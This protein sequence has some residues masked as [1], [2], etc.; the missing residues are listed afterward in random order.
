MAEIKLLAVAEPYERDR[1]AEAGEAAGASTAA[2]DGNDDL[3]K[4]V[5]S[6]RPSAIVMAGN[7]VP[8]DAVALVCRLRAVAGARTPIVFVGEP[9][10]AI[11]VE[12]LVEGAY[13]RPV[14]A[15]ELVS[16]AIALAMTPRSRR[17]SFAAGPP[18]PSGDSQLRRVAASIDEALNAEMLGAL[19]EVLEPPMATPTTD[20][21]TPHASVPLAIPDALD[22][23][24]DLAGT[25]APDW[26]AAPEGAG[27]RTGELD[28]V[29]APLLLGRLFCDG[30][31]GRLVVGQGTVERT[32]YF[33]AGRPVF[34]ASNA[35]E[36]RLI[37]MFSRNGRLTPAQRQAALKAAEQSPRK[38]GALL[39]DLGVLEAPELLA[40]IRQHYE[41]LVLALFA[42]DAGWWRFEPGLM[43]N[44][45]QIRLLRHPA[46]LLR[47]GLRRHPSKR[48]WERLGSRN[49]VF[50]IDLSG[51]AADIVADATSNAQERRV[52]LLF[53]GIR[54]VDEI[55]RLS[56]MP[57]AA[58]SELVFVLWVFGLLR[59]SAGAERG[60]VSHA[61]RD[62][63][64]DRL[65][66][67]HGI[68]L[69]GDYFEVLGVARHASP[70]EIRRAYELVCEELAPAS[71]G[72]DP[73]RTLAR[74]IHT[75]RE[76]VEEAMRVLGDPALKA[77][78]EAHLPVRAPEAASSRRSSEFS[79][80]GRPSRS[81]VA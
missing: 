31:T 72:S 3:A 38:M 30:A 43:A 71:S 58:A 59:A 10:E 23:L 64:R 80:L 40:T 16:R 19:R 62:L 26:L 50:A 53:D 39:V 25:E 11:A 2:T 48:L 36:D 15:S 6:F 1:L 32:I 37:E 55:I 81:G 57:E 69:E 8:R 35:S 51:R 63:E 17:P 13:H 22:G 18:P 28:D 45:A 74:E 12:R 66:T 21:G 44:P 34:A 56:G 68:A 4:L 7:G 70:D 65:L 46:A 76:S 24:W 42:L 78:Y 9:A 54:S 75:V 27:L 33:E 67:R 5:G 29:D 49:N 20:V 47:E 61:D 79:A 60:K 73:W 41:E 14:E 77:R 52:P